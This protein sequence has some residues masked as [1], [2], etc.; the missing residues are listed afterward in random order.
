MI[1]WIAKAT[2][3]EQTSLGFVELKAKL[4]VERASR[5]IAYWISMHA[6]IRDSA[7]SAASEPSNDLCDVAE[8]SIKGCCDLSKLG[9]GTALEPPR[10]A[11]GIRCSG[12]E[13][14]GVAAADDKGCFVLLCDIGKLVD[15]G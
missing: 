8:L 3:L 6:P 10:F 14:A 1:C 4:G 7:V 13:S 12:L 11:L 15:F 9:H 5:G 2:P